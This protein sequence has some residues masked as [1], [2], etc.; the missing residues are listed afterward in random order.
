MCNRLHLL[1][2]SS[3]LASCALL[4]CEMAVIQDI[5]RIQG[6]RVRR[7]VAGYTDAVH[8]VWSAID[9]YSSGTAA[10]VSCKQCLSSPTISVLQNDKLPIP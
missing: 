1:S 10:K 6:H 4:T 2:V 7:T 8:L 3:F 9:S 5:G